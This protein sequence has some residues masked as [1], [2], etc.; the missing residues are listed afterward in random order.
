MFKKKIFLLSIFL[1]SILAISAVSATENATDEIVGISEDNEVVSVE[2]NQDTINSDESSV[3]KADSSNSNESNVL[4]IDESNQDQVLQSGISNNVEVLSACDASVK[5]TNE[6][7]GAVNPDSPEVE[8]V[9]KAKKTK[10]VKMSVK[11]KWTTKK[12]GKFKIKARLWKVRYAY[13][14]TN[15]LDIILYKNGKQ[16]KCNSYVSKYQYKVNGKW[17]WWG[18]WRHGGVDHAYHRYINDYPI[19]AFQVKFRY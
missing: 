10:I 16:L 8:P 1:V 14:Y 9:L 11:Y 4:R 6:V 2:D 7:L 3:L 13:G 15:Y 18:R 17:K 19:K 12:I 5:N